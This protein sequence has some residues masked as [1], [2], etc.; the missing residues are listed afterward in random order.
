MSCIANQRCF[1]GNWVGVGVGVEG[2]YL[3]IKKWCLTIYP[4]HRGMVFYLKRQSLYWNRAFGEKGGGGVFSIK[5]NNPPQQF[6]ASVCHGFCFE[7]PTFTVVRIPQMTHVIMVTSS[8]GNIFRVTVFCAGNSPVTGEF[9]AQKRPVTRAFD[10][11][12]D[13]RLNKR[14]NKQWWGWWFETP[15]R[16]LYHHCN[17]PWF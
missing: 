11:F 5:R 4:Y 16:P 7:A 14:L 12:L 13:L 17:E 8:N 3:N 2:G 9:P 15:S 10:V 6:C 1:E